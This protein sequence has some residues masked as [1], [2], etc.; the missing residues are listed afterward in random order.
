MQL[1]PLIKQKPQLL[2]D[3]TGKQKS[4]RFNH[5]HGFMAPVCHRNTGNPFTIDRIRRDVIAEAGAHFKLVLHLPILV[6][7]EDL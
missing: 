5:A 2:H 1:L 7:D 3:E 6:T 4:K